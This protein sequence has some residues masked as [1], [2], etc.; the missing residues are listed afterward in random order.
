MAESFGAGFLHRGSG[1]RALALTH[2]AG[3]DC[4]A[5][6][7]VAV[8]GSLAEAGITVL[9]YNLP[10]RVKHGGSP[11]A[12]DAALDR[13]GIR[14]AVKS[15]RELVPGPVL[16]GGHSYGGRQTS[17]A[18]AE[19]G[20][21]ADALVFLSYPLHPPRKPSDLR[22]AHFPN[23]STPSLFVHGTRDPFGSPEEMTEALKAIPG[24]A[25]LH[26]IDRAGHDLSKPVGSVRAVIE[27]L[28]AW[29]AQV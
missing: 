14:A 8:T 3:S 18:A 24:P 19:D 20:S 29:V 11:R 27:K 17:M 28:I 15:L 21:L 22:T 12:G 23:I 6:L 7:L 2:G 4:N 13:D 26:L 9:R 25:E 10:F 16:A 5:P 1:E